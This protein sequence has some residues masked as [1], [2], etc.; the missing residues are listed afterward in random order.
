MARI[1]AFGAIAIAGKRASPSLEMA[2]PKRALKGIMPFMK[3]VV[4]RTWGPHPGIKPIRMAII[5]RKIAIES[6]RL[7]KLSGVN[8]I[9]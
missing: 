7:S 6:N 9:R 5:G 2:L 1:A 8:A 3:R 4:T